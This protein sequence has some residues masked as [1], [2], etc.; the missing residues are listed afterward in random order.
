MLSKYW[1]FPHENS[2][3]PKT[4]KIVSKS[5]T[6]PAP[7]HRVFISHYFYKL[8]NIENKICLISYFILYT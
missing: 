8:K 5:L 6:Y 2:E 1:V 3:R 7:E 4:L